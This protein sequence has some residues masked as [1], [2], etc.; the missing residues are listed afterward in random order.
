MEEATL[1]ATCIEVI[2][3]RLY[4]P[5]LSESIFRLF[6]DVK[7]NL[8]ITDDCITSIHLYCNNGILSDWKI[9]IYSMPSKVKPLEKTTIGLHLAASLSEFGL[10]HHEIWC[11]KTSAITDNTIKVKPASL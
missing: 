5:E 6:E 7:S 3:I 8:I 4:K 11:H 9:D 1:T 10:V 2:A